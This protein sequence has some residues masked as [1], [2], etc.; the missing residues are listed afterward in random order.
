MPSLV[1]IERRLQKKSSWIPAI[2]AIHRSIDAHK[3][4]LT[5]KLQT[6]NNHN[7]MCKPTITKRSS[8]DMI[9]NT[10]DRPATYKRQRSFDSTT[11]KKMVRFNPMMTVQ[12]SPALADELCL[13]M[14]LV[15]SVGT[16]MTFSSCPLHKLSS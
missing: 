6:H 8:I 2:I 5:A 16:A 7:T 10:F 9:N 14:M 3:I 4:Q 12:S 11:T 15:S 1:V 13:S